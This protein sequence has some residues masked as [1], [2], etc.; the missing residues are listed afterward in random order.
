MPLTVTGL[1]FASVPVPR[2]NRTPSRLFG[3]LGAVMGLPV[4]GVTRGVPS[5]FKTGASIRPSLNT[6]SRMPSQSALAA[7]R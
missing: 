6:R 5:L 7:S 4:L 3:Q 2:T 1:S